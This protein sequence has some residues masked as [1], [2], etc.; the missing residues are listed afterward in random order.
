MCLRGSFV[1]ARFAHCVHIM[2]AR[3]GVLSK[4]HLLIVYIECL[5]SG[6][7]SVMS[8][9]DVVRIVC[10]FVCSYWCVIE[11]SFGHCVHYLVIMH[12]GSAQ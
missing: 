7:Q 3:I 1:E 2:C 10:T 9:K 8:S 11:A 5:G 4:H 12:C 6:R